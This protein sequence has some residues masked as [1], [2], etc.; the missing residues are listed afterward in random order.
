MIL[1]ITKDE[2]SNTTWSGDPFRMP[3]LWTGQMRFM[4]TLDTNENVQSS[5]RNDTKI[6]RDS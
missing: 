6:S 3:V 4:P 1:I 5:E 2:N